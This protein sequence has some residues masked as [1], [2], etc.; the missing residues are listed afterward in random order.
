MEP[1]VCWSRMALCIVF[2]FFFSSRRRHTRC[3]RDWSSDVCSSDLYRRPMARWQKGVDLVFLFV[4]CQRVSP[5]LCRNGFE[6]LHSLCLEDVNHS[7]GPDG[8]I[9]M[10]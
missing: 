10:A 9:D 5:L 2:F 7:R 8:D 3:S 1:E 6:E 4:D